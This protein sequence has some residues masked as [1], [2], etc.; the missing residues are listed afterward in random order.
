MYQLLSENEHDLQTMINHVYKWCS[1][2]KMKVNLRKS[3]VMHVREKNVAHTKFVFIYGNRILE[4]VSKYK[5][6]GVYIDEFLD[7][8]A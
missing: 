2:W 4:Y 6:L 3:K 5:Y 1:R 8:T 7:Y